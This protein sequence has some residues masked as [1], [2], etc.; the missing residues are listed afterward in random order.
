[1]RAVD[2]LFVPGLV[3]T[4]DLFAPQAAAL[5]GRAA[6]HVAD[7][8]SHDT[9]SAIASDILRKAPPTFALCG[10]SMGGYIAF[11]IMRQA[12]HRV[13]RLALLDTAAEAETET[14]RA[15]RLKLMGLAERGEFAA[16]HGIFWP[17][18]VHPHRRDDTALK[19]R[20]FAM[21]DATGPAAFLRQQQAILTRP[22]SRATLAAIQCPTLVLVGAQDTLTPVAAART[23]AEAIDGARL[24]IVP[25]CGHLS[26]LER[27]EAVNRALLDWLE[28]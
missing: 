9:M 21:I 26:T 7:H 16:L 3:C 23:I 11:E 8:S 22:D 13:V 12:Q 15:R 18:F 4:G 14:A 6:V 28:R 17:L 5:A 25:D 19:A 27:P 10:L 24:E 1:M 2:I 20:V